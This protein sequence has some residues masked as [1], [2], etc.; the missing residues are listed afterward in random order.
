MFLKGILFDMKK[1]LNFLELNNVEKRQKINTFEI[2]PTDVN[3]THSLMMSNINLLKSIYPF[4]EIGTIGYSFL[5]K[6]IPYVRI[7]YGLKKILYAGS[8]HANEWITTPLLMKFIEEFSKSYSN[9][10]LLNRL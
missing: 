9:S 6:P 1:S 10:N 2:V 3:Y 5:G 7:G 8:F 4:L